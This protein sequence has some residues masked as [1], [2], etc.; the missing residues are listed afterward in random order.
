MKKVLFLMRLREPNNEYTTAIFNWYGPLE[1]LGYEVHYYDY[2]GY[3][4]DD[5]Y[6]YAK[7]LKPD[8]IFHP[9]Y[10]GFHS[11]FHRLRE[12]S[13]VYCIHSDDDWRFDNF[14]KSC[15]TRMQSLSGFSILN[16][17]CHF[18]CWSLAF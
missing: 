9:T 2:N 5:F 16:G 7:S 18:F 17:P 13:K 15:S 1:H 6:E 4:A 8:Y 3:N 14:S 10:E 11:E 12:F